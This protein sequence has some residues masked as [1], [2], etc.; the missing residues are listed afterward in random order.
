MT[1]KIT[2]NKR[3]GQCS[4]LSVRSILPPIASR[5]R[6]TIEEV[7]MSL[8]QRRETIKCYLLDIKW[9]SLSGTHSSCGYLPK[10]YTRSREL[11]S[12]DKWEIKERCGRGVG[13]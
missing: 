3:L 2:K 5:L 1:G 8:S 11:K 7:K 13:G 9:L 12:Q 10:A 6:E 4:A